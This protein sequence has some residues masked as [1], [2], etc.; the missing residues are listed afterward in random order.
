M[1]EGTDARTIEAAGLAMLDAGLCVLPA[2]PAEKRPAVH[3]WKEH[4]QR[5]PSRGEASRMLAGASGVCIV[6]GSVSG[7][8]EMIDFDLGGEAFDEWA[9]RVE[10]AQPDLLARLVIERTPS[11]GRHVVYRCEVPVAG[12][13]KLAQ[14]RTPVEASPVVQ[15][16]G[17]PYRP[18]QD[19]DR[20]VV[21]LCLIETRGEGGLFLCDP[22]PG[23]Q[24]EWGSLLAVPTI[25]AEERDLLLGVAWAMNEIE[26]E[27]VFDGGS[28]GGGDGWAELPGDAYS[29]RGDVGEVLRRHGWTLTR[30]GENQHWRRPGKEDGTSATLRD[31]CFYCF[32][33]NASPFQPN[34]AYG[35]F[36]VYALLEH[37]GD[38]TAATADLLSQ[39]YGAAAPPIDVSGL[40]ARHDEAIGALPAEP[41]DLEPLSYLELQRAYPELRKP[42]IEGLLRRGETMNVIAPPKTGKSWLVMDLAYSVAT[43]RDW[44]GFRI[45]HAGPVLMLDNELHGETLAH[46]L[47]KVVDARVERDGHGVDETDSLLAQNLHVISLRGRLMDLLRMGSLFDRLKRHQYR[48]IVIDAW[49][50]ALPADTDENDNG[51]VAALYNRIDHYAERMDCSFVLIHHT[52][53][54]SQAGKGVTDVGAGAG[55]QSRATDTHLVLRQH[56]DRGVVVLDAAVRSWKPIAPACL[57]WEWPLWGRD[58]E[59]RDPEDLDGVRRKRETPATGDAKEK[60]AKAKKE[61]WDARRFA[62]AF[63]GPMPRSWEEVKPTAVAEPGLPNKRF[64]KSHYFDPAVAVGLIVETEPGSGLWVRRDASPEAGGDATESTP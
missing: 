32:S 36:A 19:G 18:R 63:F 15:I 2:K 29:R 25:T 42:L 28:P 60:P 55:A 38:W 9:A 61:R 27:P 20:W 1:T 54:G 53:K 6:C 11:G 23:Y 52:S 10:D 62:E 3:G 47:P 50:R 17:K 57:V 44:L 43:G 45:P 24:I 35:P 48:L 33:S 8:L 30:E 37:G 22:T 56:R 46:R 49:Y 12:N 64:L 16:A 31:G 40:L 39:G 58:A 34:R 26:A 41:G 59:G 14:R 4:Q 7:N 51:G 21:D 5:L 13:L